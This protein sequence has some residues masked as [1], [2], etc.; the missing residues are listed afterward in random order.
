MQ[1]QQIALPN[2]YAVLSLLQLNGEYKHIKKKECL[3]W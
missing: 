1:L 2:Q 3:E